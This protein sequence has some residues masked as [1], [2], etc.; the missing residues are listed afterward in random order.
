MSIQKTYII[1][2]LIICISSL[3][4]QNIL[5][6][7]KPGKIKNYKYKKGDEIHLSILTNYNI[8]EN[9]SGKIKKINSNNLLIN[10]NKI[11]VKDIK[12][13]YRERFFVSFMERACYN[14]ILGYFI[15][16][17]PNNIINNDKIINKNDAII[18]SSLISS[19]AM[20]GLIKEKKYITDNKKWRIKILDFKDYKSNF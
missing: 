9:I 5:L 19:T 17:I 14:A 12:C 20:F 4:A 11:S 10:N 18:I 16:I 3:Q 6:L 1:L 2:I 15:F 7:E 8:L 13:V